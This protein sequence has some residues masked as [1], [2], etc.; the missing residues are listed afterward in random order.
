MLLERKFAEVVVFSKEEIKMATD[1]KRYALMGKFLGHC[2]PVNFVEKEMKI[3][4]LSCLHLTKEC[5]LN[6]IHLG[7]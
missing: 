2:F 1:R 5:K 4:K 6:P 7:F 3:H